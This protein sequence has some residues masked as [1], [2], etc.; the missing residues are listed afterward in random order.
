MIY[1]LLDCFYNIVEHIHE[2]QFPSFDVH[3]YALLLLK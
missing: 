2:H 1:I 3:D